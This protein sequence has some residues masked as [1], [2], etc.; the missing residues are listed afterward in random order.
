MGYTIVLGNQPSSVILHQ[1]HSL[2]SI[3]NVW[4]KSQFSTLNMPQTTWD[5]N[6]EPTINTFNLEPIV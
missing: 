5:T 6:D 3:E 4:I 2:A 1:N